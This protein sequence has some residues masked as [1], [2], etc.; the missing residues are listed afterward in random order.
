MTVFC[1]LLTENEPITEQ[2]YSMFMFLENIVNLQATTYI[3]LPITHAAAVK[4]KTCF[5]QRIFVFNS[6]RN[7]QKENS[8]ADSSCL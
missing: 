3:T 1:S 6:M 7:M 8:A 4:N 5:R 2:M